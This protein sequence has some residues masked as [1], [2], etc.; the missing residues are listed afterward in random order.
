MVFEYMAGGSL[1]KAM[2]KR[3]EWTW[4]EVT[5]IILDIAKT[6]TY[7]EA[8]K[9]VH[10]DLALRNILVDEH[11]NAKL[12]DFGLSKVYEEYYQERENGIEASVP[13]RWASPEALR[14]GRVTS[15]SDVF[16][17]AVLM[18]ELLEG[19]EVPW[20]GIPAKEVCRRVLSGERLPKPETCTE[21]LYYIMTR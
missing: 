14:K 13:T 20:K 1:L 15:K 7:L 12:S 16:S 4:V 17:F 11:Y 3:T 21:P 9:V 19:G 6:M 18:W 10:R 2:K 8:Q 5:K